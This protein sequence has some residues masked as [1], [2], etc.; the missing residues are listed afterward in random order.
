MG[1]RKLHYLGYLLV[2]VDCRILMHTKTT[3]QQPLSMTAK[4]RQTLLAEDS[5]ILSIAE[6]ATVIFRSIFKCASGFPSIGNN[7]L[8]VGKTDWAIASQ[9][10]TDFNIIL[11]NPRNLLATASSVQQKDKTVLT[12]GKIV[13]AIARTI[14]TTVWIIQTMENRV[15][16][17]GKIA[18][19]TAKTLFKAQKGIFTH[20]TI[21]YG[22]L[23]LDLKPVT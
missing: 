20:T 18:H 5:T 17:V 13:Q 2:L 7:I 1:S 6:I 3:S 9:L 14:P 23:T 10:P 4:I 22:L 12:L 19:I 16:A 15:L 8:M 11:T 21:D